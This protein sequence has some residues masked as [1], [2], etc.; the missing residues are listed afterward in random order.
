MK[1]YRHWVPGWRGCRISCG[2][3]LTMDA[4]LSPMSQTSCLPHI[5]KVARLRRCSARS[6]ALEYQ[7]DAVHGRV[8]S[9]PM[10]LTR[11]WSSRTQPGRQRRGGHSRVECSPAARSRWMPR[12][13]ARMR[14]CLGRCLPPADT[15]AAGQAARARRAAGATRCQSR[16][17]GCQ[18]RK[19]G[20]LRPPCRANQTRAR[21]SSRPAPRWPEF[22]RSGPLRC[23][24]PGQQRQ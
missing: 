2:E 17:T 6:R 4:P 18:R 7:G 11:S 13:R 10:R 22:Q 12:K 9:S 3:A 23:S 1:L 20:H 8:H 16:Y 21:T 5:R 15:A 14:G 24:H 19:R